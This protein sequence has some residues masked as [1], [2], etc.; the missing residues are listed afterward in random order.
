MDIDD[1]SIKVNQGDIPSCIASAR[2][3]L[4]EIDAALLALIAKRRA[5]VKELF[6]E[7]QR[8]GIEPFDPA[9]E[10][11]LLEDRRRVAER[12]GIPPQL[13]ED[14]FRMILEYNRVL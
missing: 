12:E 1:N 14:F 5:V 8:L 11:L 9:R 7:K 4:D 6:K 10:A 3:E 2:K 13:A